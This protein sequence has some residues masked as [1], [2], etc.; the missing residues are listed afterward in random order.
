MVS[1]GKWRVTASR[2]VHK[3]RWISL[4]AD[5]C[6][7]D[8]GAV[9]HVG[10]EAHA[11][12]RV[13]VAVPPTV[14]RRIRF[15]PELPA[16]HRIARENQSFGLVIKVQAM[17]ETPFW[18]E[19]G[20]S[21]TGFGPYL[22]VHE[23]YDNTPDGEDR[24]VLVG[25]VSDLTTDE[26]GGLD[27]DTRRQRVLDAFAAYFGDAARHP[28]G[29]VESDWQHQELTGGAYGAGHGFQHVDGAVRVGAEI[30]QRILG[31]TG[32]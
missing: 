22:D 28:V 16:G 25:F 11:A 5:D 14:V 20:L 30:A 24:G 19:A 32:G 17:Y 2:H 7:T 9:V 3:D 4:R 10:A 23:V 18:R 27:A 31:S 15:S 21:G 26:L 12:R 29:Y 1:D 13:V 8:E 6:V